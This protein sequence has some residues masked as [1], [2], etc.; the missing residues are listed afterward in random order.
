MN[1]SR[2]ISRLVAAAL[3]GAALQAPAN[4]QAT[5]KG[6]QHTV[7][8]LRGSKSTPACQQMLRNYWQHE[9]AIAAVARH[10]GLEPALLKALVAVE[11]RYNAQARSH[12]DA[13]G[14]TQ[15]LPST[16][17]GVGLHNPES[18]LYE[19]VLALATGAKYLRQMWLEFRDWPLALAAYNAGPGN[20]R[21]HKGIP[22]FPETQQ[23]V[24]NVLQLYR[25]FALA[26]ALAGQ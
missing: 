21:K 7:D 20:V 1:G 8:C 4:S 19:P 15:V 22:P 6:H 16:A 24:P 12:A 23:Y 11:S 25:E 26:D 3:L 2:T 13:R 14:L 10:Y 18:N 17:R 9:A 5:A